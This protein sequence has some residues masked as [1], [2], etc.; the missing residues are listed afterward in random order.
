MITRNFYNGALFI[1]LI[2][3]VIYLIINRGN[4]KRKNYTW[5]ESFSGIFFWLVVSTIFSGMLYF[6]TKSS[7][8]AITIAVVLYIVIAKVYSESLLYTYQNKRYFK[9]NKKLKKPNKRIN[10]DGKNGGGADAV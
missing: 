2:L 7:E 5:K 1:I 4:I 10:A 8:A 6:F 3:L 9:K